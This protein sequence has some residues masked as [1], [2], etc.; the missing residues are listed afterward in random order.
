[1]VGHPGGILNQPDRLLGYVLGHPGG[2]P[3]HSG[4]IYFLRCHHPGGMIPYT[5]PILCYPSHGY[6]VIYHPARLS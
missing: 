2:I 4:W 5:S 3:S 1:M 6:S